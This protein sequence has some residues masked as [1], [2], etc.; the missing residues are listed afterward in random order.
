M[1]REAHGSSWPPRPVRIRRAGPVVGPR[2]AT[3]AALVTAVLIGDRA[4]IAD[5]A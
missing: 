1:R 5:D 2:D 4:A 3:S